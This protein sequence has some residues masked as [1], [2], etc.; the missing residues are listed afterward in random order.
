M[1]QPDHFR[2]LLIEG[3]F[4]AMRRVFAA[5][6]PHLPEPADDDQAEVSM[7]M[8][9]TGAE[10]IPFRHRAWSHRWLSERKYP[11]LLSD[12]LKPKA[13]RLYP[14]ARP[15]VGIAIKSLNKSRQPE[16]DFVV[17]K[18]A[19]VVCSLFSEGVYDSALVSKRMRE[20]RELE[21]AKLF[22]RKTYLVCKEN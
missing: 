4:R 19:D 6:C 8:A 3:D 17:Q 1:T 12:K 22:S 16:A 7:H 21:A 5:H 10:S 11:S 2:Q 13:E 15:I 9:R 18:M 20:V 14:V